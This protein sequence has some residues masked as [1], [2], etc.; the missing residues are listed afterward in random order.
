MKAKSSRVEL[1][2]V[3]ISGL[4]AM[5]LKDQAEQDSVVHQLKRADRDAAEFAPG[6][7]VQPIG[8]PFFQA[9]CDGYTQGDCS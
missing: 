6:K 4:L 9:R 3:V 1:S 7:R 2:P 8:E 5:A